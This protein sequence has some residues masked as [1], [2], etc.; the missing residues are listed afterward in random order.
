MPVANGAGRLRV[1]LADDDPLVRRLIRD[2]LQ[3]SGI[4]VVAE[5]ADFRE[6]LELTLYYRPEVLLLD[7]SMPGGDLV[8]VL[9]RVS[10]GDPPVRT[11][12]LTTWDDDDEAMRALSAGA[13]GWLNKTIGLTNLP[14][15]VR[16]AALGEAVITRRFTKVLVDSVRSGALPGIGTRP[17]R[18]PLTRRQWEVLD[19]L[20][21]GASNEDVAEALDLSPETVRSH[22]R[23]IQ[24]K[25]KVTTRE[26]A[27]ASA[28]RLRTPA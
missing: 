19:L 7:P 27:V 11:I 12:V 21:E 1:I 4:V 18:S 20:C 14:R 26:A 15:A 28:P 9:G 16:A 25:L 2:Q 8:D 22:I 17:V 23:N 10:M 24:R 3:A 5:A 6:A 13:V